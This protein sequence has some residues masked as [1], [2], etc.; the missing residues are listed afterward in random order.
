MANQKISGM[1][2]GQP[3]SG[4]ELI[5]MVQRGLT[6]RTTVQEIATYIDTGSVIGEQVDGNTLDIAWISGAHDADIAALTDA[7]NTDIASVSAAHDNDVL[8]I[9]STINSVSAAHANDILAVSA[10]SVEADN[11][12]TSFLNT[13]IVS[14]SAAVS[15]ASVEA[16]NQV[17]SFLNT[18]IVSVS[19]AVSA[20]AAEQ[21][22]VTNRRI[23]NITL[24]FDDDRITD[25][26]ENNRALV[27]SATDS[28]TVSAG[29]NLV[30]SAGAPGVNLYEYGNTIN[31][32]GQYT[33]PGA[34]SSVDYYWTD[35]NPSPLRPPGDTVCDTF[36]D[37]A[38]AVDGDENTY[39]AF[40]YAPAKRCLHLT[41]NQCD[42]TNLG[43]ITKVEWRLK[44]QSY[45]TIEGYPA[46]NNNSALGDKE[47]VAS[48][49]GGIW[50]SDEY[51]GTGWY[52]IT[53]DTNAPGSGNWTWTDIQNLDIRFYSNSGGA[54]ERIYQVE[55]RVTYSGADVNAYGNIQKLKYSGVETY[56]Q[57][58]LAY[59]TRQDGIAIAS[60]AASLYISRENDKNNEL[61]IDT[62][63]G[64][65]IS[66]G[67]GT[68]G[69]ETRLNMDN[70]IF[71]VRWYNPDNG[72]PVQVI[73]GNLTTLLIGN[74]T[75][76]YMQWDVGSG[77]QITAKSGSDTWMQIDPVGNTITFGNQLG[78]Y[79][80]ANPATNSAELYER[81]GSAQKALS[82]YYGSDGKGVSLYN[83]SNV[84][85]GRIF[86]GSELNQANDLV[87]EA[88]PNN[89]HVSAAEI[90]LV[91]AATS[92][93][94]VNV[95]KNDSQ[96]GR[97]DIHGG[98][99][100][101]GGSLWI[102]N[103][104]S[105]D[106]YIDYY[107]IGSAA[108]AQRQDFTIGP[109]AN[110]DSLR[111]DIA[112]KKWIFEE[113]QVAITNGLGGDGAELFVSNEAATLNDFVIASTNNIWLSAGGTVLGVGTGGG[114][115][116]DPARIFVSKDGAWLNDLIIFNDNNRSI[117]ISGGDVYYQFPSNHTF[118][119][120]GATGTN[121]I[122]SSE[123]LAINIDND[124]RARFRT[125]GVWLYNSKNDIS[126]KTIDD[127][128]QI[129]NRDNA[130]ADITV[131][132]EGGTA[133]DL[134]LDSTANIHISAGDG[135]LGTGTYF[136]THI[137]LGNGT[138]GVDYGGALPILVFAETTEAGANNL[139]GIFADITNTTVAADA[140]VYGFY[141]N[142]TADALTFDESI[143]GLFSGQCGNIPVT[144]SGLIGIK[145]NTSNSADGAQ[146]TN[147][148]GIEALNN[149]GF[150]M[151][152]AEY[153]NVIA[154][155]F[156][157]IK[158]GSQ[159]INVVN[160]YGLLV[161]T[162][163]HT[164]TGTMG[165]IYGLYIQDQ[166]TADSFVT[167]HNLYS[168]G[169]NST[170]VFEGRVIVEGSLSVSG[171]IDLPDNITG[172]ETLTSG[173]ISASIAFGVAQADTTYKIVTQLVNTVDNPP[174][175]YSH[176]IHEKTI[177][178]FKILFS[179][180]L[181][182]SNFELDWQLLR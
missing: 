75:G 120:W 153:T 167:K 74:Q 162:P 30:I 168:A 42:G 47:Q 6:R 65:W 20:A 88:T 23:D 46:Y 169:A 70:G 154:G 89:I 114:I 3:I 26:T 37:S 101:T 126:F 29:G 138:N 10:A 116:I 109:N 81:H 82:T 69:Q 84:E 79:F 87:L 113:R 39:A 139:Y 7:H 133:G 18:K 149:L 14:V 35:F 157:S 176:V 78:G 180:V 147:M 175:V 55:V 4:A 163:E 105:Y 48:F 146:I 8:Q 110:D 64:L 127:G 90:N 12:V 100:K 111:Y 59:Q 103:S 50:W 43:T 151:N 181:D 106:G 141:G 91:N 115:D 19:A 80:H 27:R 13:K 179:G 182:S 2:A 104:T 56:H 71:D 83:K 95:G 130:T 117:V 171:G 40:Q 122:V 67:T 16:D 86:I 52:D 137:H 118:R 161:R 152:D 33:T 164:S 45:G 31:Y 21:N 41:E 94:Q 145:A 140:S 49:G 53:D 62:T 60:G 102:Y 177:N 144:G 124:V 174:S 77:P 173:A 1:T 63:N 158:Y 107:R 119:F 143:G 112:L 123:T 132:Y 172:T 125:D 9:Y 25:G 54:P 76:A 61:V 96:V 148:I 155:D 66:A 68:D 24:E 129:L 72:V 121:N 58:E 57:N 178:G 150:N 128:I 85:Q 136:P 97:I 5:E 44:A 98:T 160:A 28:F 166:S 22:A 17:T 135:T 99:G 165:S 34:E 108:G 170:N 11:Q 32:L 131:G 93:I 15:A 92:S 142:S 134:I 73:D 159:D 38:N 156:Q 51:A 36:L